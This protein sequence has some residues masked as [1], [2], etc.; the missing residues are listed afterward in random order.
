[1]RASPDESVSP[2]Q[3]NEWVLR[4]AKVLQRALDNLGHLTERDGERLGEALHEQEPLSFTQ[5][6][7]ERRRQRPKDTDKQKQYYRVKRSA[8]RSRIIWS[9]NLTAVVFGI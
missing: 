9:F 2:G 8:T 5:D 4:Y 3:A 7:S 1:M 6:G